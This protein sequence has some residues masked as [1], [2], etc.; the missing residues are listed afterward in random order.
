MARRSGKQEKAQAALPLGPKEPEQPELAG[1]GAAAEPSLPAD[2]LNRGTG[3]PARGA[4]VEG[5]TG[6][7][8][9]ATRSGDGERNPSGDTARSADAGFRSAPP[10]LL[11]VLP[12]KPRLAWQGMDRP[13]CERSLVQSFGMRWTRLPKEPRCT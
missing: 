8:A 9:R 6:E 12:R 5:S 11:D 3:V 13:G 10:I 1:M 7:D 2:R 4:L